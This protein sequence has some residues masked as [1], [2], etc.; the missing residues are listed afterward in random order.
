MEP[1]VTHHL[2]RLCTAASASSKQPC[3]CVRASLPDTRTRETNHYSSLPGWLD[4][5]VRPLRAGHA[6][7]AYMSTPSIMARRQAT[8]T[9]C[10]LGAGTCHEFHACSSPGLFPSLGAPDQA[11]RH[12]GMG[13]ACR[14]ARSIQPGQGEGARTCARAR[15]RERERVA[16]GAVLPS[17][18][19]A[20]VRARPPSLSVGRLIAC[21]LPAAPPTT[22]S[23]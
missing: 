11:F 19:R 2:L 22:C 6:V 12:H 16:A 23:C 1:Y 4:Q 17:Y 7:H 8:A 5:A 21:V 13:F 14:R 15:E 9:P 10:L 18:L 3:W 20:H